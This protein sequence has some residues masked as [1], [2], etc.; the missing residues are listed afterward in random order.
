MENAQLQPQFLTL[1]LFQKQE[2]LN[3]IL[4]EVKRSSWKRGKEIVLNEVVIDCALLRIPRVITTIGGKLQIVNG[5]LK[6]FIPNKA[7]WE[8]RGA[9]T[10]KFA[11]RIVEIQIG[12]DKF[13][14]N[15]P[16][17]V[18]GNELPL[19]QVIASFTSLISS[20]Y[21]VLE[22]QR[23]ALE[24][25]EKKVGLQGFLMMS[26]RCMRR[27]LFRKCRPT[28]N[29]THRWPMQGSTRKHV[30]TSADSLGQRRTQSVFYE[31]SMSPAS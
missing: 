28:C 8:G 23:I 18:N 11:E 2:L 24:I 20:K 17:H 7:F 15:V 31:F 29:P 14:V 10:G 21:T 12:N 1:S 25:I 4:N 19:E 5:D 16:L 9:R 6:D 22:S 13:N 30:K 26:R 3:S 27:L